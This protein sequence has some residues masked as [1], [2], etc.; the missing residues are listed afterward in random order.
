MKT[1]KQLLSRKSFVVV[2][3]LP[4]NDPALA[5]AAF[6]AGADAV[7]LHLNV[8]HRASGRRFGAWRQEKSAILKI[9]RDRRGPVGLMPGAAVTASPEELKEALA[10]GVSFLDAYDYDWPAWMLSLPA[11]LMI[12]APHGFCLGRVAEYAALGMGCLEA[13]IIAPED[14]G[15][16]LS[17]RDLSQY[18]QLVRAARRPVLVPSQKALRPSDL[19]LLRRAGARGVL[20]GAVC[21]GTGV[22]SWKRGLPAFV[23]AARR[24]A[25]R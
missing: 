21:L 20:L 13:S 6:K 2:A 8:E 18:R 23:A 17:A 16:P 4:A 15:K 24:L 7:K 10:A 25:E 22:A 14:Y 12:A 19:A 9:L 1:F 11:C 3:S 5:A